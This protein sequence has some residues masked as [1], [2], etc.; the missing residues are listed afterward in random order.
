MVITVE[1]GLSKSNSI[2]I[3][4]TVSAEPLQCLLFGLSST[5]P[6]SSEPIASLSFSFI[7]FFVD[8]LLP[9]TLLLLLPCEICGFYFGSL[10]VVL[11]HCCC[12]TYSTLAVGIVAGFVFRHVS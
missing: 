9:C 4:P 11:L 5:S 1:S 6:P 12:S 3:K 10:S 8:C 7:E 2:R